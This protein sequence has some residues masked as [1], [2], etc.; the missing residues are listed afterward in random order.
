M[1]NRKPVKL[2]IVSGEMIVKSN[3]CRLPYFTC[4][5][6]KARSRLLGFVCRSSHRSQTG[7]SARLLAALASS[8][9]VKHGANENTAVSTFKQHD[10]EL[11]FWM[12][13]LL[14]LLPHLVLMWH[15]NLVKSSSSQNYFRTS[16]LIWL[17]VLEEEGLSSDLCYGI[18]DNWFITDVHWSD[19]TLSW[20]QRLVCRHTWI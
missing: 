19:W 1:I 7:N 9:R 3:L 20:R 5:G 6:R 2:L 12:D 8:E 11:W 14:V 15:I 13:Y 16:C 4:T 17:P 18:K 10:Q